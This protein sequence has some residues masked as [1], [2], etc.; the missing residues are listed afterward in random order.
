[1]SYLAT[2]IDYINDQLV[3]EVLSNAKY[4][5]KQIN[6]LCQLLPRALGNDK[7]E[8]I[9]SYVSES[10]E[11]VYVGPDDD[12]SLMIYH[13]VNTI[14][15]GKANLST[16]GDNRQMDANIARMSM[17]VFGVRNELQMTNDE[18]AVIIQASTPQ[19]ATREVL[20][21]LDFR[22]CNININEIILNDMQ[23]FSEEYQNSVSFFLKPEQFLFKINYSIES[24]F[25]KG[26]FKN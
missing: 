7:I 20:T 23:V 26:C 25:L 11:A 2:I 1:M 14:T 4:E 24:T 17:V 16:Y 22:A 6:G 18:L 3:T 10:G 19:A 9:P 13:R 8:I 5:N 15:V 21:T 12:Y